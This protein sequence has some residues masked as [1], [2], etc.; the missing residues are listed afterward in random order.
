MPRIRIPA[1]SQHRARMLIYEDRLRRPA[2][3]RRTRAR[4]TSNSA[5]LAKQTMPNKPSSPNP[6]EIS[7]LQPSPDPA[8]SS[9]TEIPGRGMAPDPAD[10]AEPNRRRLS[11]QKPHSAR[12]AK[13]VCQTNPIPAPSDNAIAPATGG[14]R[15][16]V[17]QKTQ[18]SPN[19]RK[20]NYQTDPIPKTQSRPASYGH[21]PLT[22]SQISPAQRQSKTT[23]A[24]SSKRPAAVPGLPS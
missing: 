24:P 3:H 5:R 18:P 15:P 8:P 6:S 16:P 19:R 21:P 7:T 12:S 1:A 2:V 17:T 22:E 11:P 4:P 20:S 23:V 13:P 10:P 9:V 14:P